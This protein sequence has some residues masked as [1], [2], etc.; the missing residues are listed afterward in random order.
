MPD[1]GFSSDEG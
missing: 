1:W